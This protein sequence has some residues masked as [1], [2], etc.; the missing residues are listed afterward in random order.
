MLSPRGRSGLP[1]ARV[2]C[3]ALRGPCCVWLG[4]LG[5]FTQSRPSPTHVCVAGRRKCSWAGGVSTQTQPGLSSGPRWAG[6]GDSAA[7]RSAASRAGTSASGPITGHRPGLPSLG[8][9]GLPPGCGNTFLPPRRHRTAVAFRPARCSRAVASAWSDGRAESHV[10]PAWGTVPRT[11]AA[12]PCF[13]LAPASPAVCWLVTSVEHTC[14]LCV[15]L[16]TWT[17]FQFEEQVA[18]HT[19]RC[20]KSAPFAHRVGASW[21]DPHVHARPG[22]AVRWVPSVDSSGAGSDTAG[23]TLNDA[24]SAFVVRAV[25]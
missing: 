25:R 7:L 10:T 8:G 14:P 22:S 24:S 12:S 6:C 11:C 16:P 9:R 20:A 3:P 1:R 2:R 18:R 4:R 23:G 13:L 5:T 15:N 17:L 21:T 19:A